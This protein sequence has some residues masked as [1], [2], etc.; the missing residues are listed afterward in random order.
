M[1]GEFW[2]SDRQWAAIEPL[3]PKNQPGARRVD[4]RRVISGIV[5]VLRSGAAG[6]IARRS[7]ARRPRS[8]TGFTAGPGAGY[9]SGCCGAGGGRAGR[10]AADRQHQRKRIAR[11]P[12]EKGGPSAGDRPLARRPDHKDPRHRRQP[13]RPLAFALTAGQ[14]GDA[15]LATALIGAVPPAVCVADTAYDSDALRR[16]S[17]AA[18]CRSFPTTQPASAATPS[19]ASLPARNLIERTFC[20]LKDWRRIATRYDKLATNYTAAIAL[21]IAI[22]WWA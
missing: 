18:R 7:T 4:D 6:R 10:H 8:I 3:L 14:L 16:L 20:R 12:A 1:A 11:R 15:P 19:T 21:A 17:P 5:H 9:G 22:T 2:F 13:W